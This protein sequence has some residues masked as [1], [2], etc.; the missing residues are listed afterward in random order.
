M[1][2][3]LALPVIVAQTRLDTRAPSFMRPAGAPGGVEATLGWW[4]TGVSILVVVIIAAL[5]IAAIARHRG[6]GDA[7]ATRETGRA[8]HEVADRETG[9]WNVVP[10]LS[11]INC[12]CRAVCSGEGSTSRAAPCPIRALEQSEPQCGAAI[13]ITRATWGEGSK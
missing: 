9:R 3:L 6:E 5:V 4:L 10:G 1:R 13:K 8:Q 12:S 11:W 2:A 7:Q